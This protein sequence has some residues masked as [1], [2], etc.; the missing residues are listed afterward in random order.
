[1]A[2]L[3]RVRSRIMSHN[4]IAG[5]GILTQIDVKD[6]LKKEAGRIAAPAP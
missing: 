2:W 1:M 6:T 5:R 4:T 3:I